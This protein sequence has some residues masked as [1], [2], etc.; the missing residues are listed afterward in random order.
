MERERK[1]V[2]EMGVM[3]EREK[4]WTNESEKFGGMY[5]RKKNDKRGE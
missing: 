5:E 4:E 3:G 1:K 2:R